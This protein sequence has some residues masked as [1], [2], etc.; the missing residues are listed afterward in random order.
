[1]SQPLPDRVSVVI[2]GGGVAGCSIAYHLTKLGITDVLLLERRQ[3]TC[4]T[5]W[6]AAG[7]VGQ[8]RAT[9]RMTELAKYTSDLFATL[10]AE[11]GQA[12]GFRQNGS[13]AVALNDAR[14][15]ELK[16]G[17]SMARN[18]GLEVEVIGPADIA[19]RYP[20]LETR[21]VKG[22]VFLA[23]DGQTNPIDTTQALAKGARMRG[24]RIVENVAVE[25]ILVEN[26][27]AVGVMTAEGPV[28]ADTVVL[29]AGMWSR[30]LGSAVGVNVPLHACEH[31][32]VVT[33]AIADLPAG[34]PVLRVPDEC[35]YY[36][37]DAGK[38]LL[39]C[40]EPV[41]KPW[42][43]D[44]IPADFAFDALPE[45]VGHFEPILEQATHRLPLLASAGIRTFFNGPESFTPDDR[46]LLGEA[47][48]LPNLFLACGFNSIGIQ[49]SGG[50][51][52]VLAEWI[53]DRHPPMELADVDARRMMPF[54]SNR[55][56]LRA[57]VSETL[58]LLYDMH[59]PFRQYATSRGAR[60]SPFHDRLVAAGACMGE[61]AGWE[62]PNWYAR[63]GE[64]PEYVYSYGRQ[65]WF[66]ACG[67]E[68]RRTR[69]AV[70]LFD[71]SSFAKYLVQGRD[72]LAVLERVSAN[73]IDVAPGRAVYT[74]WLN[75]RGGIEADLTVTRL[76]ETEF[77]VVTTAVG[78]VRDLA[79]LRRHVPDGAHCTVTDVTSGLPMLGVMGPRSR[80]LLSAVSPDDFSNAAF[81]F[82][83]SREVEIGY[84]RV[85]A[86]RLTYV[87]ELGW[88]LYLPAEF[89]AHVFETL[90]DAGQGLGLGFAGYHAMNA[91]RLEKGYRH[92]GH[93]I[94]EEDDPVQAGLGFAVAWEKPE[95]PL[96]H[97]VGRDAL[98]RR[99]AEGTPRRRLVQIAMEDA[100]VTA[101][102]LYR[103][104]PILRD[105]V[106]VGATT[107]GMWGHR[108]GQS[109]GMGYVACP[110]GVSRDWLE[111]GTWE[112]E[113][114][115]S[116]HPA[117]VQLAPWYDPKGERIRG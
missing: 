32:Y 91:L 68:C 20:I 88:E 61:T 25:R 93:D 75:A 110:E 49:S 89:A 2:V 77:L 79:W 29:A 92:W 19:A 86:T 105:G 48:E 33:E 35:T 38:I 87:G 72:A 9:R 5:T 116:R 22:G 108:V 82:G 99:R 81:P 43:M 73:R 40:F 64:T 60:R 34:L 101:P 103:D 111:A 27:R 84:A 62:R 90:V 42:G 51:G 104:E 26:G 6:H 117:R 4:G 71:Q 54:Q 96:G 102:L 24:A 17:A 55:R 30:E 58:G 28:R 12:T 3:L 114:A 7:L 1:M 23:K 98:L 74:Q 70:A 100:G 76:A 31:F 56:Y 69:D 57:R 65:N 115:W 95:G 8:L 14:L 97:F 15:E 66:D 85:R 16:R 10:E 11:T 46:Y 107:S 83:A 67:A 18:F 44:G 47:P 39:G 63:D 106:P 21:D 78:Q 80:D 59:W 94:G 109:L 41:A 113:V 37:E 50:V 45:D 36:K 53:R 112:V 13:I 52:K